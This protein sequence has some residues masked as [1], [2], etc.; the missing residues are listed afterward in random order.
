MIPLRLVERD[1]E[2]FEEP[3]VELWRNDEF[4]GYVFWDDDTPIVQVFLDGDGDPFDLDLRDLQRI[5]EMADQIVSPDMFTEDELED[6]RGRIQASTDGSPDHDIVEALAEEFDAEALHRNE[7]GEG[8][9][10]RK[11]A[12]AIIERCNELDMAVVEMEGFDYENRTLS[13]RPNLNLLVRGAPGD[14]WPVF[15][16]EANLRA[17]QALHDWPKRGSLV[18]AFVVQL[19]DG[20]SVV[21]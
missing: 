5:L 11:S 1:H 20:E 4:V 7:E 8:F 10:P 9:Y 15:R 18:V 14:Q 21:L 2:D 19:S 6:L 13:P 16:P 17:A 3:I 12:E